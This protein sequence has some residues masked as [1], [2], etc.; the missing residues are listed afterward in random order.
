MIVHDL[1]IPGVSVFELEGDSPWPASGYR[2]LLATGAAQPVQ[3]DRSKARQIF[4]A[5]CFVKQS[6]PS[7]G[8]GLIEAGKASSAFF[9]KALRGPIGP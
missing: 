5:L 4:Q 1:D 7:S 8:Q 6:Q 3:A 2:P 9:G